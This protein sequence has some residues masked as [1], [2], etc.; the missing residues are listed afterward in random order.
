MARKQKKKKGLVGGASTEIPYP[1]VTPRV[2]IDDGYNPLVNIKKVM[3]TLG[4][5][6][7]RVQYQIYDVID[8]LVMTDPYVQ[9]YHHSTVA[10]A[11]SGHVLTV[12]A[13]SMQRA[14]EAVA[15]AN[16]L[17]EKCFP[18]GG[19]ITGLVSSCFS[20]FARTNAACV[21]WVPD[22]SLSEIRQGFIVPIK[23][24]RFTYDPEDWGY[25][26]CQQQVG[27]H[28]DHLGIVPLNP[29]QTI[30][31][32]AIM[33]DGN[34]YPLPPLV[35]VIDSCVAHKKIVDK[36]ALWMDKVS[37]LGVMVAE[38]EPP[39]RL[40]GETQEKYD[41]KA[42]VFLD[43]IAK[44]ISTNMS[45]GLG[46]AYNNVKF[47][48]SNTQAGA[49]GAQD[50]LQMVLLG[51]FSGLSRDPIMFG[52]NL[53]KSDAFVKV[54]YEELM[55]TLAFYQKGVKEI[56]ERGHRLNLALHGMGDCVVTVNFNPPRSLDQFRD[57]EA[58]YMDSKKILEQ[59]VAL[60]IS[61]EEA[62]SAL[63]YDKVENQG[64]AF[65]AEF[66]EQDGR[67]ILLPKRQYY[68][69]VSTQVIS[70][71][72]NSNY[73]NTIQ[74]IIDKANSAGFAAFSAWLAHLGN[75]SRDLV[76]VSG[77][78]TYV[79]ATENS[80]DD[81]MLSEITYQ[82]IR[83]YWDEG[84]SNPVL[85]SRVRQQKDKRSKTEDELA[86][87]LYLATTVE[88]Y[89][90]KNFMSRSQWRLETARKALG[91]LYDQY[92]LDDPTVDNVNAFRA[93][94]KSYFTTMASN[95][96]SVIG[97]T[98][99]TRAE[100][101]GAIFALEDSGIEFFMI[102][103][104]DDDRTCEFCRSMIGKVFSVQTEINNIQGIVK[105]G[106]P[107]ISDMATFITKRFDGGVDEISRLGS[108]T[109]QDSGVVS[110]PY[111]A[112]CRHKIIAI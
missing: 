61:P 18:H 24:V 55:R 62:R 10:L 63:G 68:T 71:K 96:A 25:I 92:H 3:G 100:T 97:E 41:E 31:Y 15:A 102:V 111:H 35:S 75:I 94:A 86:A 17:A 7:P 51:L 9:K 13:P 27:L 83:R 42:Q 39:P 106:D 52:W 28:Q 65:T 38:V 44:S 5:V 105:S 91:N 4:I 89:M 21:E 30:Y 85:F 43:K 14:Q 76:V 56:I 34:P 81:H 19:D 46:V 40:P 45:N 32:N 22:P 109:L 37:A 66:S 73:T 47:S 112:N 20:Q 64:N 48:F 6:T 53:G 12:N 74:Y 88:P 26:L 59:L 11:N 67:Y 90:V 2:S 8:H 87:L 72:D 98:A 79:S 60:A 84:Q 78:D 23:T 95:A 58:E 107:D 33:R 110:P 93:A 104:P 70:N 99:T 57:S 103:G 49:A 29:V 69:Q 1:A 16:V 50:L 82:D 80:I 36:I 54:I 101:W 77:V 108:T